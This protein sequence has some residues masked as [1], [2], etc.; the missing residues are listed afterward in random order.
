MAHWYSEAFLGEW[1]TPHTECVFGLDGL[2][3]SSRKDDGGVIIVGIM[4][5][6]MHSGQ[7]QTRR[8]SPL[9]KTRP[10]PPKHFQQRCTRQDF[11]AF[12]HRCRV[13]CQVVV[14]FAAK[15][16]TRFIAEFKTPCDTQLIA[17]FD[18]EFASEFDGQLFDRFVTQSD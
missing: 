12:L 9:S 6:M 8:P 11:G 1:H 5:M 7:S 4:I 14:K 13:C 2:H 3:S 18:A 16:T 15:S 17:K 10:P